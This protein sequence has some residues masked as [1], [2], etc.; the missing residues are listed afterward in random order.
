MTKRLTKKQM[1]NLWV[2]VAEDLERDFCRYVCNS[3]S[4]VCS[5]HFGKM[6]EFAG[7]DPHN[8]NVG[9]PDEWIGE[10]DTK[11]DETRILFAL[12]MAIECDPN[13]I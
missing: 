11:Y 5:E 2:D 7:L 9:I 4:R 12:F 10:Y 8:T 3:I 13:I 1:A 6:T